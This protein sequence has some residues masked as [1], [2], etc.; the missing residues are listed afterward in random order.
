MSILQSSIVLSLLGSFRLLGCTESGALTFCR[1]GDVLDDM[2]LVLKEY[3]HVVGGQRSSG[4]ATAAASVAAGTLSSEESPPRNFENELVRFMQ[5]G[6]LR[7]TLLLLSSSFCQGC[8]QNKN[9]DEID[10]IASSQ[11]LNCST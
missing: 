2:H 3:R 4:Q 6:H 9:V 8:G 1:S 7:S 10:R 11:H 5:V